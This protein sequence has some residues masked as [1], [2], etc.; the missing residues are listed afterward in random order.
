[1]TD[2]RQGKPFSIKAA[3]SRA[4]GEAG[5][6]KELL[7][8]AFRQLYLLERIVQSSCQRPLEK[9]EPLVY[10]L[11]V[12]SAYR[13]YFLNVPDYT[14]VDQANQ[15]CRRPGQKSL[16]NGV[17]RNLTRY[18]K[19][20]EH[21]LPKSADTIANASVRY[22]IPRWILEEPLSTSSPPEKVIARLNAPQQAFI[23]RSLQ[24]FRAAD[25]QTDIKGGGSVV[26]PGGFISVLCLDVKESH[27]VLDMGCAPGTKLLMLAEISP[28]TLTGADASETRLQRIP[29]EAKRLGVPL[30]KL[31]CCDGRH[32]P[33][34]PSSFDRIY[35][36]APCTATGTFSKHPEGKFLRTPQGLNHLVSTQQLLLEAS[37]GLLKPGGILCYAT[38]SI[39]KREND[40]IVEATLQKSSHKFKVDFTLP[41]DWAE[42]IPELKAR[43]RIQESL[44]RTQQGYFI[45]PAIHGLDGFYF[46]RIKRS[47]EPVAT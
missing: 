20:P 38:C 34:A 26:S 35:L 19:N 3:M 40:S 31:L 22:S 8:G 27:Q 1:M 39:F 14:V 24:L 32:P 33:F 17:L 13:A 44:E 2:F 25:I 4:R 21:F 18:R 30:P 5:S 10:A 7:L 45:N 42:H 43:N 6:L 46:A 41:F 47:K 29:D 37:L 15:M 12:V 11:L 16:I 23:R 28:A 36:D 9:L